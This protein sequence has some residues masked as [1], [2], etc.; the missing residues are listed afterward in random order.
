MPVELSE[1]SNVAEVPAALVPAGKLSLAQLGEQ[2]NAKIGGEEAMSDAMVEQAKQNFIKL[3]SSFRSSDMQSESINTVRLAQH[4][5][6]GVE[7][8]A[9]A[10]GSGLDLIFRKLNELVKKIKNEHKAD[11][12]SNTAFN[13]ECQK[14]YKD[15]SAVITKSWARRQENQ[16]AI[17]QANVDI[18][19]GRS[20]WRSSRDEEDKTHAALVKL[21]AERA[22]ESDVVRARVNE[23]NK[24]IDVMV[25][26]TFLVCDRFNRYKDTVQ[27]KEI[28]SQPD[29]D[30]PHRFETKPYE[31]AMLETESTHTMPKGATEPP[32]WLRDWSRKLIKDRQLEGKVDPEG[33]L[34]DSKAERERLKNASEGEAKAA[35]KAKAAREKDL[36]VEVADR[37]KRAKKEQDAKATFERREKT[38]RPTRRLREVTLLSEDEHQTSLTATEVQACKELTLL[39]K[40]SKLSRRYFAPLSALAES[41]KS[42]EGTGRSKTIV[43]ILLEILKET[44]EE[45]AMDKMKHKDVLESMYNQSWDLMKILLRSAENQKQTRNEKLEAN[46]LGILK[47]LQENEKL[48][49]TQNQAKRARDTQEDSCAIMN[50]EYGVREMLRLEDL[51]NLAKLKSL[52]RSLYELRKPV[53]CPKHNRVICTNKSRGW[54][55]FAE[56]AGNKQVCSCMVGFYGNACQFRM[57]PGISKNLYKATDEGVCSNRGVCD[58]VKGLCKCHKEFYHGPKSACDYKHAPPSLKTGID[59]KCSNRGAIDRKRGECNCRAGFYGPGC[60]QSECSNSNGVKYPMVSGNS[61]NGRGACSIKSGTCSCRPPYHG[62]SCEFEKCPEDCR[63]R[64][65]CNSITGGCACNK[66]FFGPACEFHDCPD[67]CSGGG[68]CDR[69]NGRC[70]CTVGYSGR[71]CQKTTRCKAANLNNAKMNWWTVWDK[72][73]WMVCPK[74]QLLY[75]LQRSQCKTFKDPKIK[76]SEESTGGA[77]SCIESGGCA[78]GCEGDDHVFQLRHCYHDLRW[79]NSFDMAGWSQ[80]LPDYFV[81]GLFRSCES[82]Y[83]L[84]MAKCCSLKDSRWVKCGKTR[85]GPNFNGASSGARLG[86]ISSKHSFITGFRRGVGHTLTDIEEVSWCGFVRGY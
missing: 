68:K 21:Q 33:L 37:A 10:K 18:N 11:L 24:A 22:A 45:Q 59:D 28:K 61:C 14:G 81:A 15:S 53:A 82:L 73:G 84:N 52:L 75:Q 77:L 47:A 40:K 35:A 83:C 44:R 74:G 7:A 49:V 56:R 9:N 17:D 48:R 65:T 64:G 39:T 69:N 3:A 1:L 13:T 86:K 71:K 72:P 8:K 5:L 70:V 51:E 6:L 78:A 4:V 34:E 67:N 25:K 55:I 57:C 42:G 80:C 38:P 19:V 20:V 43:T 16:R 76:N 60:E 30:E 12:A 26:A 32:K 58:P 41:L 31:K 27:C 23:R 62:T 2:E 85:W 79:Y 46:R 29:V 63:G 36:K 66:G 50:E 54:C